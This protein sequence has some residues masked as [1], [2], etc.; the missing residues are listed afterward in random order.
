MF[1]NFKTQ[2]V[3]S[4]R[5]QEQKRQSLDIRGSMQRNQS[6]LQLFLPYRN[7]TQLK[8]EGF[9][10]YESFYDDGFVKLHNKRSV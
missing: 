8:P 6:Q 2:K 10:T 7:Q 9:E 1:S 3:L 5:E 4:K